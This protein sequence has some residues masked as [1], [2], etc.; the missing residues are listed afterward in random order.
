MKN[1]KKQKR[2]LRGNDSDEVNSLESISKLNAGTHFK[3]SDIAKGMSVD[4]GLEY[5]RINNSSKSMED[6]AKRFNSAMMLILGAND[7]LLNEA[8][9]TEDQSKKACSSVK[10]TVN[11]IKDQLLKVDS[12]LGDNVEHKIQQL[13]RVASALK[14]ISELSGDNKTMSI[15]SAMVNK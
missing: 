1:S 10:S 7:K 11:E 9:R 13:E 3:A 4:D 5:G 6:A 12:I 8:K 15:V 14:T 2:V